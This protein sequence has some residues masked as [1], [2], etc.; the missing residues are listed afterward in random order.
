MDSL[1]HH[2][3]LELTLSVS[4]PSAPNSFAALGTNPFALVPCA[5]WLLPGGPVLP[6]PCSEAGLW[7][8]TV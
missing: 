5:Q 2:A 1:A 8:S 6:V 4:L 3:T 7:L